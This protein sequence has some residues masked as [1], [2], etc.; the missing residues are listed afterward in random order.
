[1]VKGFQRL[2]EDLEMYRGELDDAHDEDWRQLSTPRL[3]EFLELHR[4]IQS[5]VDANLV[6]VDELVKQNPMHHVIGLKNDYRGLLFDCNGFVAEIVKVFE[7]R[8]EQ[9]M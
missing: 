5:K 4:Y 1:M 9:R 7:A 8:P 6:L 2:R 3:E